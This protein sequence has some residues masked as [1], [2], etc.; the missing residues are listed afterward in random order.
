MSRANGRPVHAPATGDELAVVPEADAAQVD[1]AVARAHAA[2]DGGWRRST[3]AER[4]TALLA[5]AD[6]LEAHAPELGPLEAAQTG[7]PLAVATEEVASTAAILRFFAGAAR[8]VAAPAAAEY[9]PGRTSFVRREPLGVVA[10]ILPWNYPLLMAA[11]KIGPV[12]G[13]GNALVLKPS[14]LTPLTALRLAELA[15]GLLPD[16]VLQVLAGDGPVAG[17]RLAAHP[18]VQLIALTGSVATGQAIAAAA[19]PSLKRVHLELGGKAPV[20]VLADADPAAVARGVR[21]SA[22]WNA[23]Q[24]CM[25]ATRVIVES[26]AYDATVE[27]LAAEVEALSVGPPE[28]EPDMGPLISLAHRGRVVERVA[29][30]VADGARL[31]VGDGRPRDPGAFLDPVLLG[32]VG[33][34]DPIVQQELFGPV[35][36]VQRVA[37]ER[38]ALRCANDVPYGLAASVWTADVGRAM[39]F[40]RD[41]GFGAVWV[42][43]HAATTPEMPHSGRGAS[44]YGTDLSADALHEMTAVKHVMVAHGDGG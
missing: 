25:A 20:V 24:D 26:E 4:A 28:A 1:A 6:R 31:I 5:L 33:Q 21:L 43:E 15:E 32:D 17:A 23:G 14:E 44:G 40:A 29:A 34:R 35:V 3:P 39:R 36:T 9:V 7:K 11:Y 8:T 42:N 19:A 13:A 22:Y 12:I 2:L 27:A 30:A 16:G 10:A 37:D 41:L 18:D 38:E